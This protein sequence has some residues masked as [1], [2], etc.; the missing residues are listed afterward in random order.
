MHR[1]TGINNIDTAKLCFE[2]N[3]RNFGDP[4]AEPEKF[5]L[6]QGLSKMAATLETLQNDI[7]QMKIIIAHIQQKISR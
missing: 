4:N 1:N 3:L 2:E 7:E 6:Y 5:N